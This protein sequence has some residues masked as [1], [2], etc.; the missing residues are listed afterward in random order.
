VCQQKSAQKS[1]VHWY[2]RTNF[3]NIFPRLRLGGLYFLSKPLA[4]INKITRYL[5]PALIAVFCLP[6]AAVGTL[7]VVGLVAD[8][9]KPR[10]IAFPFG[11]A[12]LYVQ[13]DYWTLHM[14]SFS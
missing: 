4:Q 7:S 13:P 3:H 10:I 1:G 2:F 11:D 6:P 8:L 12:S 5:L 14:D 9:V